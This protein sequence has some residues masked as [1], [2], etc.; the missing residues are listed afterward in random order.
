[1]KRIY[2]TTGDPDGIGLEITAKAL[3]K[4]GPQFGIQF[5]IYRSQYKADRWLKLIDRKFSRHTIPSFDPKKLNSHSS[6]TLIDVNSHELAPLWF[7]DCVK[8]CLKK[9]SE[10]VV[11]GPLSKPLF[12]SA[13]LNVVGHTG[14]LKEMCKNK[15]LFMAFK[16]KE[17]NVL[18]ATDHI[19]LDKVSAQINLNYL[20]KVF[21]AGNEFVNQ[22]PT[23]LRK[24]PMALLGLNPHSGDDGIIGREEIKTMEPLLK[25]TNN[26]PPIIGPIVP[27][28]AFLK[29]NWSKYSLYIC[30]YHDQGLIPFKAVHGQNS[31][32]HITLGLP[33]T[34][35]SVDHGTAIDIFN[36]N[37]ASPNSMFE[38]IQYAVN[39]V[40]RK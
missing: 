3:N 1:M 10:V 2:L 12:Y 31:G 26:V 14:L 21:Q 24:K 18:L 4:L 28:A 13:G 35:V 40:R 6:T 5:V 38:A 34:R 16:G 30:M 23:R 7:R 32:I 20:K 8:H 22:L 17:F 33:F 19:P 15:N 29:E 9:P 27:D 11:T 25:V 36:K 37:K 39:I